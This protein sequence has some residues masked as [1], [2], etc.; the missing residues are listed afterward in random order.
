MIAK[1]I[2]DIP[3]NAVDQTY[4]YIVPL[5]LEDQIQTGMRVQVPFS[6]GIRT[7]MVTGFKKTST[8]PNLKEVTSL[9][10]DEKVISEPLLEAAMLLKKKYATPLFEVLNLVIPEFKRFKK[11]KTLT[12]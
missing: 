6:N 7:G 2:I 12:L 1:V 10:D 5:D 9:L 11:T 4:D 8:R 3:H